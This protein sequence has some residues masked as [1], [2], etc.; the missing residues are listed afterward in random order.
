MVAGGWAAACSDAV[1]VAL[2]QYPIRGDGVEAGIQSVL[3]ST[4]HVPCRKSCLFLLTKHLGEPSAWALTITGV[5][6]SVPQDGA[7]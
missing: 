5:S 1:W 3:G 4:S 6:V 7:L 2:H